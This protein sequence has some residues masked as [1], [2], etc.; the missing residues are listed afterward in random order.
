MN[1]TL[2]LDTLG[3]LDS[4]AARQ[5]IDKAIAAAVA[6]VD[7]RGDDEKPRKV[8]ITLELSKTDSGLV[9]AHVEVKT[10]VPAYRTAGTISRLNSRGGQHRLTFQQYDPTNPDQRTIDETFSKD[11]E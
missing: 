7:D 3:D 5:V 4:G 1:A 2:C 10:S 9:A 6:D 8:V 11:G